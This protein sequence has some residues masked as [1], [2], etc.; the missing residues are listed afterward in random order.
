MHPLI[1]TS[2]FFIA[3]GILLFLPGW[4][5]LRAFFGKHGPLAAFETFL[6]S[7]GLS[8]G[9]ID[10]LM[11]VI[12]KSD[13]ALDMFSL[14]AGMAVSLVALSAMASVI[15]L[16]RKNAAGPGIEN[17]DQAFMFSKRQGWLFIILIALT[18]LIKV[19][20][21]THAVLPTA[22]DLGHHMYWSKLIAT[23]GTLPS[24]AK[25]EIIT[26]A[27]DTYRITT[28]EPIADFIIGE[29]LPFAALNIFTGL[30]FLSAFPVLL[31]WLVNM[32]GL[33]AMFALALR[34]ASDIRSPLFSG[35]IFTPQNIAL[36]VL[37][38]FGPLYTLASPQAK[39]VSG[40]VVGNTFG[41]FFI[42]LIILAYYRAFKEK[43]S[44]FL[45][46]GFFLTFTLA[47]TH[48]LS[49]FILLFALI[50]S[51]F[52]YLL[53]RYD[54]L[55]ETLRSWWKI[56]FSPAPLLTVIFAC[57]FF[58]AIAMPAYIETNAVGTA[59]GTPTKTTRTGLTFLQITF[60]SGESR[61]ALGLA[62][63]AGLL[64]CV[65]R[66]RYAMA[67]LS[68][69]SIVLL[70][71]TLEPGWLFIDI[72][73]NRIGAYLSFPLGML[74]AFAAIAFFASLRTVSSGLRL[75]HLLFLAT[76]FSLFVFSIGSGSFDNSQTL[77]PKS[78][79]FDTVQTFAAS[80]YLKEQSSPEDII[81]KD[82]NYIVADAWMKLFF[83][84]DYAYP[85]S[86]GFF[87]RYEDNPSR[88]QCTLLMISV[89]NTPRGEKCYNELG[90]D[91]IVVN[92][93]FDATQFEKS[94]KFSRIYVS[95]NIH[96]YE[97]KK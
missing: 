13:M 54:A 88:E 97:R 3:S 9:L 48:H 14:A 78:K 70:I 2:L 43:S 83:L 95:D 6:F 69:W 62:G 64:A 22:T 30:D 90:V 44:A 36:S 33:F 66:R 79:A 7:F 93:H 23:T 57:I 29:H 52:A 42:P 94:Q 17:R 68:G 61:V 47:Y 18:I 81:L 87:K 11:I 37:F 31:L 8:I 82:H 71:M 60:S 80:R 16:L 35:H 84:R 15:R 73:S 20:Y 76:S 86:R 26:A 59:I 24:Y 92:P 27:D 32:L 77:L 55:G 21:L 72:P 38:F 41:N 39:F 65:S 75:P 96:I 85:L 53:F 74:A 10:F 12:G 19:I 4:V 5:I 89:P 1:S 67:F 56:L 45:A 25:Q 49:V 58:F 50:A 40:G 63:L 46:L 34:L 91:L 51:A 28:P